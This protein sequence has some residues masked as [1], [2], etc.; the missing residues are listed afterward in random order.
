[1]AVLYLFGLWLKWAVSVMTDMIMFN[2][3]IETLRVRQRQSAGAIQASGEGWGS[4]QG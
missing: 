4:G 2:H 3:S 1:M